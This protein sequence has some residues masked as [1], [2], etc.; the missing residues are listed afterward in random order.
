MLSWFIFLLLGT[1]IGYAFGTNSSDSEVSVLL[2]FDFV[3]GTTN[4]PNNNNPSGFDPAAIVNITYASDIYK[5][6]DGSVLEVGT[7]LNMLELN[8][9][10]NRAH[11]LGRQ[12]PIQ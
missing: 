9:I 10:Q 2:L 3:T 7:L 5:R 8:E 11:F 6:D 1:Q 4:R 12:E